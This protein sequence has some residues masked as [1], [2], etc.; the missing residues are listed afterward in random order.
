MSQYLR[1]HIP[2]ACVFF[3]IALAARGTD[4]LTT[5]IE[6]LRAAVRD[7]RAE[8]PFGVR[9]IAFDLRVG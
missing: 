8:R 5:H 1:P 7:T 4:V 9:A 3:T 2:S 6:A